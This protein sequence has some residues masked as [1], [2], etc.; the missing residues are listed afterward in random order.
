MVV[1]VVVEGTRP[2]LQQMVV[3]VVQVAV[4]DRILVA[5]LLPQQ[6]RH[7]VMRVEM[8]LAIVKI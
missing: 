7:R 8:E 1:V 4:V 6:H 3:S 5:V 2:G